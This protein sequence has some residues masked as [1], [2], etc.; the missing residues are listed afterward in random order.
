MGEETGERETRSIEEAGGPPSAPLRGT[1]GSRDPGQFSHHRPQHRTQGRGFS[2]SGL[3]WGR[4]RHPG[5]SRR[6]RGRLPAA[7]LCSF[8]S[9]R[10][11]RRP[12]FP[13]SERRSRGTRAVGPAH[14][15]S[16]VPTLCPP[17][18][19]A[20]LF[21]QGSGKGWALSPSFSP[22]TEEICSKDTNSVK[23]RIRRAGHMN[24]LVYRFLS[25]ISN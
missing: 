10:G 16:Q 6:A 23:E 14:A 25:T 2:G 11:R 13:G 21:S 20:L 17:R 22:S 7:R 1:T 3:A 19:G 8:L 5:G 4:S 15:G 18:R 9:P 24:N 12:I